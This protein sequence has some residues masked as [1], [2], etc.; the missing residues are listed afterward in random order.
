[1]AQIYYDLI[2]LGPTTI[3]RIESSSE[4]RLALAEMFVEVKGLLVIPV[5]G[6]A[7]VT[8]PGWA[9]HKLR[10]ALIKHVPLNEADIKRLVVPL[11]SNRITS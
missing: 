3:G 4:Y 6:G 7:A 5:G 1:M 10:D 9:L 11:V 8:I 2:D